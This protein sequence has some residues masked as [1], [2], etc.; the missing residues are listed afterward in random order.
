MGN[1][2]LF[3]LEVT[4]NKQLFTGLAGFKWP[5][6]EQNDIHTHWDALMNQVSEA[7]TYTAYNSYIVHQ[8]NTI[9]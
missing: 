7:W 5:F 8:N 3:H 9:L 2:L 6:I 1:P 4:V